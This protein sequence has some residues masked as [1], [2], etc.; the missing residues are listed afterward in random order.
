MS[1]GGHLTGIGGLNQGLGLDVRPYVK[2]GSTRE[3]SSRSFGSEWDTGVT[4]GWRPTPTTT[5]LVTTNTDFAETE[6]DARQV[7][8][9]R[10]PLFFPEKRDF[11]LEDAGAFEFGAPANRRSLLPFFSRRIGRGDDGEALPI[12]AG[13]KFTGRVGDWTLGALDTYVDE[14]DGLSGE[15][16]AAGRENLGVLR[17]SRAIGDGQAIGAIVTTGDPDGDDSRVTGGVDARFGSSDFLGPGHSGFL[18]AYALGSFGDDEDSDAG[19]YG[20]QTR[21]QSSRWSTDF[22]ARRVDDDFSPA[23]GFVRRTGVDTYNGSVQRTWRSEDS[24]SWFRTVETSLGTNMEVDQSGGEDSWSV[25]LKLFEGTFWNEDSFGVRVT[26]RAET[27]ENA[28]SIGDDAT[29]VPGDYDETRVSIFAETNDR[30][31]VGLEA[32]YEQGDYYGG[33]IDRLRVEPVFL[34]N[35]FLT[36]G[37]SFQDIH[38]DLDG[39]GE[40]HTQLYTLRVDVLLDMMTAWKSFL[41]YD[42][43]SKNLGVQSRVRWIIEPGRELFIVGL[44]GFSKEDTRSSFVTEDQSLAVKLEASFRF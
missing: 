17:V 41:Q 15:N 13:V 16:S 19:A 18:W 28:F 25:P 38:V 43:E 21:T 7:N 22:R 14:P 8:L 44:F 10:F 20:V 27:I 23:V 1:D 12:L 2:F 35:K 32:S 30:R 26:R 33:T 37:G 4:L 6:V 31:L 5:L 29:V 42:T 39:D 11:F 40:L 34:P 3:D 9:G 36:L 24:D